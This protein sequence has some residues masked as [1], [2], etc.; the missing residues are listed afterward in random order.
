MAC[1]G[2]DEY[3]QTDA[4]AGSFFQVSGGYYHTC[5]VGSTGAIQ[6]WG[7]ND[8]GQCDPPSLEI[9]RLWLP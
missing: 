5:A 2:S 9:H 1:W 4:P 6:C 3:G 7:R 8:H